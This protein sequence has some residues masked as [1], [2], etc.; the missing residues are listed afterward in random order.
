MTIDLWI[1]AASAGLQWALIMIAALPNILK[2]GM[3]WATGPR[4]T[5]VAV[6][7]PAWQ[8][9]PRVEAHILDLYA[10]PPRVVVRAAAR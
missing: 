6:E 9:E 4:D 1:L 7:M 2:K 10:Y 3:G 8:G 5:D